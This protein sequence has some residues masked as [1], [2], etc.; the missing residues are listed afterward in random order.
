MMR[1]KS[2]KVDELPKQL[3]R[4]DEKYDW[5]SEKPRESHKVDG[6]LKQFTKPDEKGD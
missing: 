6:F 5:D 3:A 4:Y 1:H 2:Q